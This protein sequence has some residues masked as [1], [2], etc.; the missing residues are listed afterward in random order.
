MAGKSYHNLCT[1]FSI[2]YSVSEQFRLQYSGCP[3]SQ[4]KII[5]SELLD[6]PHLSKYDSALNKQSNN[7]KG[8]LV[9]R[10]R[11]ET[12]VRGIR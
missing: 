1:V 11:S 7:M 4:M 10:M 3:V 12:A 5:Q 6:A 9:R 8:S 2:Q